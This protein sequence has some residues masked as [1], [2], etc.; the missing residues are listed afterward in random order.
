M[1]YRGRARS[2]SS[3]PPARINPS[4]SGSRYPFSPYD[5]PAPARPEARERGRTQRRSA[6]PPPRPCVTPSPLSSLDRGLDYDDMEMDVD[7]SSVAASAGS[8]RRADDFPREPWLPPAPIL[9]RE[10][11]TRHNLNPPRYDPG[12]DR[13]DSEPQ[14]QIQRSPPFPAHMHPATRRPNPET[15]ARPRETDNSSVTAT[16][17]GDRSERLN[18][19]FSRPSWLRPIPPFQPPPVPSTD[20]AARAPWRLPETELPAPAVHQNPPGEHQQPPHFLFRI[21]RRPHVPAPASDAA[22]IG[23]D[24]NRSPPRIPSV[25][26]VPGGGN[27]DPRNLASWTLAVHP[28][29]DH[30]PSALHPRL[31]DR[32]GTRQ[33]TLR[34]TTNHIP[35]VHMRMGP[36][37]PVGIASHTSRN[38]GMFPMPEG[39]SDQD[40]INSMA[41]IIG[42]MVDGPW[43]PPAFMFIPMPRSHR[44]QLGPVKAAELLKA[45]SSVTAE[46][47]VDVERKIREEEDQDE[48]DPGWKCGI[49]LHGHDPDVKADSGAEVPVV[50][51][52]ETK[53]EGDTGVK[54]TPCNHLFHGQCLL[55]W[56][57]R[58]STW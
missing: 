41:T 48:E 49:C 4:P 42:D 46:K 38:H 35:V 52:L 47:M 1:S 10:R 56:F 5:S 12:V 11:L 43:E 8:E 32:I 57:E 13:N 50:E 24:S 51:G 3:S 44:D 29:T 21:P 58:R 18:F 37:G 30:M 17:G 9:T 16:V 27:G 28:R 6:S 2:R 19:D 39:H 20:N 40:L 15:R 33:N 53:E 55:P 36:F 7:I 26:I 34:P 14:N 54:M 45:L 23:S 31:E 22:T 25:G